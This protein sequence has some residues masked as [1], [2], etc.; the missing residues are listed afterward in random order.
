[1]AKNEHELAAARVAI[2][3]REMHGV[4]P[5]TRGCI[6]EMKLCGGTIMDVCSMCIIDANVLTLLPCT[7]RQPSRLPERHEAR[8]LTR[9]NAAAAQ[10]ASNGY[11]KPRSLLVMRA[12]ARPLVC[13]ALVD[14]ILIGIRSAMTRDRRVWRALSA[15]QRSC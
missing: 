2:G 9:S 12:G 3:L 7:V 1:M 14:T 10:A 8:R 13:A 6:S 15:P 11:Q 4:L 5:C